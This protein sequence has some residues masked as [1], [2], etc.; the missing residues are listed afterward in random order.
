MAEKP[1]ILTAQQARQANG[2][3]SWPVLVVL[4]VSTLLAVILLAGLLASMMA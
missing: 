3:R 4:T 1:Q 2:W